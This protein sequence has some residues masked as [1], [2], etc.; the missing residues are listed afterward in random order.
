MAKNG[1]QLRIDCT[2]GVMTASLSGELD[3]HGAVAVRTH[4]DAEIYRLSPHKMVLEL[5][6]MDFMDSSGLGLIM[7]RH[8]LMQRRGGELVVR[9]ANERV[10]RIFTLAGLERMV[11]IEGKEKANEGKRCK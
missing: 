10:M 8:A 2:C 9:G 3:H 5:E 1:C 4:I 11:R 7:G 6:E